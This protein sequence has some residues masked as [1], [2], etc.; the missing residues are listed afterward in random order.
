MQTDPYTRLR[1]MLGLAMRAGKV[2]VG[3]EMVCSLLQKRSRVK[4]VIY[5]NEAS[6][7][8]KRRI[9]SKCEFYGTAVIEVRI[10]TGELGR[11]LGKTYGPACVAV[12]DENFAREI[13]RCVV[14][15]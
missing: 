14:F 9:I 15:K 13:L 1:G 7:A 12:T 6:D 11:L 5:S 2:T 3:T 8:T 4:L 10:D